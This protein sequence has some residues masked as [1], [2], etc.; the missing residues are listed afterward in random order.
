MLVNEDLIRER[1]HAI[2]EREGRPVGMQAEHW[3]RAR[4]ECAAEALRNDAEAAGEATAPPSDQ[5]APGQLFLRRDPNA[6]DQVGKGP[7][8]LEQ[9][10]TDL[11]STE[12]QGLPPDQK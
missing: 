11:M 12:T 7:Q 1:A 9:Q 2:W 5:T 10:K 6:I 3:E 8:S 4:R